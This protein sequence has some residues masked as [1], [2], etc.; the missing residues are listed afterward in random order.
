M[1]NH[2]NSYAVA[3][4]FV[5]KSPVVHAIYERLIAAVEP[6][7]PVTQD[8]KKTSIHLTNTTAFAGV[9]TQKQAILLTIRANTPVDSLR[10]RKTEQVSTNRYHLIVKLE[11]VD[12]VDAE[13]LTLLHAAYE[14]ST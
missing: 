6:F 2:E 5:G 14:L 13:L 1:A 9:Q 7:G 10:I 4:H 12:D 3:V 11:T 8:P